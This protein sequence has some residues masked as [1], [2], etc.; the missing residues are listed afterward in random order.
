[1]PFGKQ[2]TQEKSEPVERPQVP[3]EPLKT[4]FEWKAPSRAYKERDRQYFTT[5]FI[6]IFVLSLILVFIREFL[7]IGVIISLTFVYYVL[8]TVPPEEVEHKITTRGLSYA[9]TMYP[10][11]SL[12]S[13]FFAKKY[14]S[15]V[16]NINTKAKFPG[17]LFLIYKKDDGEKLQKLVAKYI[18]EEETPS[19][20]LLEKIQNRASQKLSLE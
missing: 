2:K 19:I 7:L 11:E 16:L 17:R 3:Q 8:S 10:W 15:E 13:F 4:L 6:I 12:L 5:I 9:G 14:D 18:S 1:M 20:G